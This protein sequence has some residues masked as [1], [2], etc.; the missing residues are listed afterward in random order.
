MTSGVGARAKASGF[1]SVVV[2]SS[3]SIFSYSKSVQ[4]E[5]EFRI[6]KSNDSVRALFFL[7]SLCLSVRLRAFKNASSFRLKYSCVPSLFFYAVVNGRLKKERE[8]FE[9][10]THIF[11]FLIT[12]HKA[13]TLYKG[14]SARK[15]HRSFF[16]IS[17][18]LVVALKEE[19]A[20]FEGVPDV[21][22]F[23]RAR[24]RFSASSVVS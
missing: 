18:L 13:K 14:A 22:D 24:R 8:D 1:D 7:L 20:R 4:R 6:L 3:F 21:V 11:L 19:A 12:H 10:N 5:R 2:S 23:A 9:N 15:A 16:F 17:L